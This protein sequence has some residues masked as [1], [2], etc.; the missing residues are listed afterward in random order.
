MGCLKAEII[1][2]SSVIF[3]G[4]FDKFKKEKET[5]ENKKSNHKIIKVQNV[6]FKSI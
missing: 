6:E 2:L 4:L 3:I 1:I 5:N